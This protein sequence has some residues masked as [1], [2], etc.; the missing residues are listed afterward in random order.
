MSAGFP[1]PVAVKVKE[2]RVTAVP[3]EFVNTT[4]CTGTLVAPGSWFELPGGLGPWVAPTVTTV[5]VEVAVEV[6]VAVFTR[7][8]VGVP[9]GVHV[10]VF[11]T[12]AVR[13][14]V[15]EGV[16]VGVKE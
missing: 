11:V 3:L 14:E 16:A 7:V 15:A 13:V 4:C 9:L 10:S 5:G 8:L 12:V 6:G 1:V 2:V